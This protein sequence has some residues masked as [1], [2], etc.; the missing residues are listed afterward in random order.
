MKIGFSSGIVTL[1]KIWVGVAPST[2]AASYRESEIPIMPAIRRIVVFPNHI[3]Q[4]MKATRPLTEPTCA[5]KSYGSLNRPMFTR[6]ELIGPV[7]ANMVKNSIAKAEAM[8][9]FGR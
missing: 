7:F 5:M 6:I 1:Q 8:I 3:R 9:R 4:F 2:S